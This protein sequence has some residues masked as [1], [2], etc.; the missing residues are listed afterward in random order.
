[1]SAPLRVL[2]VDDE[3]PARLLLGSYL[4]GDPEV[5]VVGMCGTVEEAVAHLAAGDT[6][7]V[8]LDIQLSDGTGF[9]VLDRVGADLLPMVV[10]VTAYDEHAVRA[11]E[12][13][14]ID[15]LLKPVGEDRFLRALAR[16]KERFADSD[17][18]GAAKALEAMRIA[19]ELLAGAHVESAGP[20]RGYLAA[21]T[22]GGVRLIPLPSVHFLSVDGHQVTIHT[23]S[24]THRVRGTLADFEADLDAERFVRIHRSTIVN[25]DFVRE[26]KPWFRGDYLVLLHDGTELRLSRRYRGNLSRRLASE[27]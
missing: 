25:L 11:F 2:V 6:D 17:G 1:V 23:A 7:A 8:F 4:R 16:L 5:Q 15:Y 27:L 14:A 13:S 26:L 10:F 18:G 21:R 19:R 22:A 20:A 9:D 12:V 24:E 3:P